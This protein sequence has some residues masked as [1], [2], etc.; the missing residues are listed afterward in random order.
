M[1][2]ESSDAYYGEDDL[3]DDELDID[4]LDEVDKEN[5]K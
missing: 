4:W 5:N 2:E 1:E 3:G